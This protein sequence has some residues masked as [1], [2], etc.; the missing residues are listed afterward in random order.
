MP[1]T[2]LAQ[3]ATEGSDGTLDTRVELLVRNVGLPAG[4][5]L[6][7]VLLGGLV[8]LLTRGRSSTPALESDSD[9]ADEPTERSTRVD[10]RPSWPLPFIGTLALGASVATMLIVLDPPASGESVFW[11][12]ARHHVA[13]LAML[14]TL[15]GLPMRR[16]TKWLRWP[17]AF[18]ARAGVGVF[19]AW[20]TSWYA[21]ENGFWAKDR[22]WIAAGSIG[23]VLALA[24][25]IT[26]K[27]MEHEAPRV[28]MVSLGLL[29]AG[30]GAAL[31]EAAST[32]SAHM[33]AVIGVGVG[34]L[35]LLS[36][37]WPALVRSG[38]PAGLVMAPLAA[39]VALTM[40]GEEQLPIVAAAFLGAAALV[41]PLASYPLFRTLPGPRWG[42]PM[43]T[44]IAKLLALLAL[45][46][47]FASGLLAIQPDRAPWAG[48]SEAGN[49]SDA[50]G[51]G[52]WG[53][54][55]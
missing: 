22:F 28:T 12:L 53:G 13:L 17:I 30:A 11:P 46:A 50:P 31:F 23:F 20:V 29:A 52:Q 18:L 27:V 39:F 16:V 25:T 24:W 6:G 51:A 54:W 9:E 45:A 48:E 5:V 49:A 33:T 2:L 44:G 26:A 42:A 34:A 36:L 8:L 4:I 47:A 37:K 21:V 41:V 40:I 32:K 10:S 3:A 38:G 43:A 35:G 15:V 19:A 7:V 1:I 14:I 55:E